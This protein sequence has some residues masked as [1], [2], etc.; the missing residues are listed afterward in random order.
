V[1]IGHGVHAQADDLRIALRELRHER[2]ERAHYSLNI[3]PGTAD[4]A[5]R[6]DVAGA[7]RR[8]AACRS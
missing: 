4:A 1:V 6:K 2:G 5:D 7:E 8:L 3:Q